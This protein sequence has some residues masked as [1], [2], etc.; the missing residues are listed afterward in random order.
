VWFHCD[1]D[2]PA[3]QWLYSEPFMRNRVAR[4]VFVSDWQRERYL[5]AFK[6]PPEKCVVLRNAT[7]VDLSPLPSREGPIRLA[8]TSTPFRG[9]SV[10][11]DA[12]E[13]ARPENAELHIWS[14]MALY[15]PDAAHADQ[16][17]PLYDRA[18]LLPNV[19]YHGIAPNAEVRAALRGMDIWVLPSTFAETSCLAA[20]EAMAAGCKI[21]CPDYGALRET[22]GGYGGCAILYSAEIDSRQHARKVAELLTETIAGG[23]NHKLPGSQREAAFKRYDWCFRIPEWRALIDEVCAERELKTAAE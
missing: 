16:W 3:A 6:L 1:I 9:L 2:Q 21:I 22:T 20:I 5:E 11:L 12:W 19:I 18:R 13:I 10:L 17:R 23:R 15:G 14:G 8:Y 4:F 7:E